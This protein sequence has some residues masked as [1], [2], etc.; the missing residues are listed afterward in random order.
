MVR[1]PAFGLSGPWR[2]RI[3]FAQTMEQ[4]SGMAAVTGYRDDQPIIPRGLCDPLGGLHGAVGLLL[5]LADREHTGQGQLVEATMIEAAL[6][7]AAEPIVEYSA[8]GRLLSRM[9]NRTSV[10][11]PSG[12]FRCRGDDEWV[13]I[14]VRTDPQ[15]EGLVH[16]IDRPAALVALRTP[17]ERRSAA[18][19][20]E[21]HVQHWCAGAD[22][23]DAVRQLTSAGVPAARVARQWE[24][25]ENPQLQSRGFFKVIDHPVI[26]R[27][28]R[29]PG[30]PFS[31]WGATTSPPRPAPTLGEDN[32]EVLI[33]ELGLG[34]DQFDALVAAGIVGDRPRHA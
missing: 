25:H 9:G 21:Q 33:G 28:D 20:I 12:V 3:G 18:D 8:Y 10:A 13:A 27:H 15:W 16:T 1:M 24:L 29:Y 14:S 17:A 19:T 6:N 5:A 11:N 31:I 30:L 23:H 4:A 22:V 2:D 32:R 7:I 34:M 26:G